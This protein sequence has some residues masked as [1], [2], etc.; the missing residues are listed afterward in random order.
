MEQGDRPGHSHLSHALHPKSGH[1]L[2]FSLQPLWR[3][4]AGEHWVRAM[5]CVQL[6]IVKNLDYPAWQFS[7]I[8][9]VPTAV[10]MDTGMY[11]FCACADAHMHC[12]LSIKLVDQGVV[13]P[14][15][16]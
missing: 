3:V 6:Y 16:N 2:R 11:I 8:M 4:H 12:C 5:G 15:D 13:Y 1:V 7:L 14:F 10:T 9:G